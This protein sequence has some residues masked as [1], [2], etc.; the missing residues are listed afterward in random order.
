[1]RRPWMVAALLVLVPASTFAQEEEA[2]L[3]SLDL[4]H[5]P[6]IVVTA[7][8][9]ETPLAEVGASMSVITSAEIERRQYRTVADALR[10]VPG[11][12]IVQTGGFG[13][14]TSV[15]LRGAGSGHAV[16]LM[17]GIELNDPSSPSGAYD[18]AGLL[19]EGVERIEV[20]R[21][22]QSTL[23]GSNAMGGVIQI[24]TRT[25]EGPARGTSR[26]EAG[27][28]GTLHGL[29]RVA[30]GSDEWSWAVQVDRRQTD[31]I[32]ASLGGAERDA[33]ESTAGSAVL[34]WTPAGAWRIRGTL[35]G[36][37]GEVENDQGGG[38][39]ADDPN[40]VSD[41]AEIA[42]SVEVRFDG[43]PPW[44]K[45]RLEL[46]VTRHDREAVDEPDPA[47]P[48]TR[49]RSVFDGRRWKATWQNE[50][51]LGA[52]RVVAGIDHEVESADSRFVSDGEFGPFES[53]LPEVSARTTGLFAEDRMTIGRRA[54]LSLGIRADDH[55]RFGGV[56][57][58]RVAPVLHLGEAVR[59]RGAVGSGFRAP[60]LSQLLD[61][62]FGNPDLE[63]EKSDGVEAGL[64]VVTRDAGLRAG[65]TWFATRFEDLIV[66]DG[67]AL[68]NVGEAESRGVELTAGAEAG[69]RLDFEAT[70]TYL[71]TEEKTGENAGRSLLRRPRHA[72]SLAIGYR[73]GRG[74]VGFLLRRVGAREDLDFSTFPSRRVEL[75]GYTTLRLT[76]A[77]GWA[78]RF[79]LFGRLENLTGAEYEEI[80]QF[81]TPGRAFYAGL[82]ATF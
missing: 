23:H 21:G 75:D 16:V 70:Y 27:S 53:E 33:G 40:F 55:S 46:A 80:F 11:L 71:D 49:S 30:A 18:L 43:T 12:H 68:R 44:W 63:P 48:L 74:E 62:A 54:H 42:G 17:D 82:S 60:S 50:L 22:P 28:Y 39:G 8:R 64:D 59:L 3:D 51:L 31:G 13:G 65:A 5:A 76:A 20:L 58:Y 47:R 81:G 57:T 52:H 19:T 41:A 1:M 38:A 7:S 14:V 77:Y 73:L 24:L 72:A 66:F 67:E 26:I 15:F 10:D 34:E 36:R 4:V 79:R 25:G 29:A 69:D 6:P 32:S 45:P 2:P 78:N 9:V 56:V 61:P 35:H 37:D